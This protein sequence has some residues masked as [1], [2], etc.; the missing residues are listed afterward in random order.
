MFGPDQLATVSIALI[1]CLTW[2]LFKLRDVLSRRRGDVGIS[3]PDTTGRAVP[4][5][6]RPSALFDWAE[7]NVR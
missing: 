2:A 1:V 5:E 4:P 6:R 3:Q 7:E